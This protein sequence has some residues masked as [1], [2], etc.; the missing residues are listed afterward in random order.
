MVSSFFKI[1]DYPEIDN[2]THLP[3]LNQPPSDGSNHSTVTP[4][5]PIWGQVTS[6]ID[7]CEENYVQSTFIAEFCNTLSNMSYII[8]SIILYYRLNYKLNIL[9]TRFK[10]TMGGLLLVGLGSA[11]FHM[12]LRYDCQ[13]LDEL[14]MIYITCIPCYSV[15]CEPLCYYKKKISKKINK[16]NT[17]DNDNEEDG[18]DEERQ[19]LLPFGRDN[20]PLTISKEFENSVIISLSLLSLIIT[21]SYIF[22]ITDPIFHEICYGILNII[23]V[24]IS[25]KLTVLYIHDPKVKRNLI[26]SS[27]VGIC[28]FLFGFVL[29]GLDRQYC[30]SLIHIRREYLKLPLG[31]VLELHA[32][33]HLFT[34]IG[35]YYILTYLIFL[36]I[37]LHNKVK[38]D[39]YYNT[40]YE[41]EWI[42]FGTIPVLTKSDN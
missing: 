4:F 5:I 19:L 1:R 16:N 33:W 7:W 26:K 36:R 28:L 42:F 20:K 8:V 17:A 41:M 24:Y 2:K 23:I 32:Y 38:G 27:F 13:L 18:L 3:I 11:M 29:W 30:G 15:L 9:E 37:N 14:P 10:L 31:N 21:F 34:G 25:T 40:N 39:V 12:S 22:Y 35:L 6:T